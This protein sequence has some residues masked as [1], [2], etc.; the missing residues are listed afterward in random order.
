MDLGAD[1]TI[2]GMVGTNASG[3]TSVS[4]GIM[5]DQVRDLEDV[6]ASRLS[7]LLNK[8]TTIMVFLY[9]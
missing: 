1:A 2:E 5:R 4:Y 3:T 6:L 7:C 8:N 9:L